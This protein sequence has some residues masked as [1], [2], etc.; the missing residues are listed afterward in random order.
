VDFRDW[1][2][3]F[4]FKRSILLSPTRALWVLYSEHFTDTVTWWQATSTGLD[5]GRIFSIETD[6]I[7]WVGVWIGNGMKTSGR[8]PCIQTTALSFLAYMSCPARQSRV[9]ASWL[10]GWY[11]RTP[12]WSCWSVVCACQ[13]WNTSHHICLF[14]TVPL[15]EDCE[16][17]MMSHK[18]SE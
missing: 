4:V 14:V 11:S 3:C 18:A 7:V 5:W 8:Y 1:I 13:N 2:L 17:N 6:L 12:F 9:F 15:L 10:Y 16:D